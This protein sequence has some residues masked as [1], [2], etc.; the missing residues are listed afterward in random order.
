MKLHKNSYNSRKP[1]FGIGINDADYVTHSSIHG[2]CKYY[3]TWHDMLRRCYSAEYHK[4]KPTYMGCSV[5]EE[6][7][8]FSN[9]KAWM[10]QQDWQDKQL[11]KDLLFPGNKIYSPE[12]CI[13]VDNRLNMLLTHQKSNKDLPVGVSYDSSRDLYRAIC[14]DKNSKWVQIGRFKTAKE[15][16]D[17]Y[18]R[19][20]AAVIQ[21]YCEE[22]QDTKLL[23]GLKQHIKRLL[24]IWE[25]PSYKIIPNSI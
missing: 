25:T 18:R 1:V 11:D 16:H 12:T 7:K 2:T 5:C 22:I 14:Q 24:M 20:K 10:E 13:F 23:E 9:F 8:T 19:F 15:A 4:R 3:T 6:W 17:A 21:E